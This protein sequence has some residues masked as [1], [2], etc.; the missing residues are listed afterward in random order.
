MQPVL[1][2]DHLGK[3]FRDFW[4]RPRVR[5]VDDRC[6]ASAPGEILG[7]LGPNG[8]GKSTTIKMLLGLLRPTDGSVAVFG[9]RPDSA[10]VRA[11]IGY[12]PEVSTLYRHLTPRETLEYFAALFDLPR[13]VRRGRI[14]ELLHMVGL[15]EA[16]DR[17]VGE[18]SKGMARRVG[19][20]QALVNDPDFVVLDEPTSG[21]DPIGR[22]QVKTL[23]RQLALRGK[24]VLLSSHLLAEVADVCDRVAVLYRGRLQASGRVGD[25]LARRE[26]LRFTVPAPDPAAVDR[27]RAA[28]RAEAG[29]DP[30]V[31]HPSMTLEDYFLDIIARVDGAAATEPTLAPF[32]SGRAGSGED[33]AGGRP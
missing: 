30:V 15:E 9:Q 7:L 18:F 31:D 10:A 1:T 21:L 11:R 28:F 26:S 12:L 16:A 19:L 25:L 24:T 23:I 17:P 14:A 6:L 5:A 3:T 27:L 4:L 20:A 13:T 8:S 2:H 33:A 32:L 22:H 29:A